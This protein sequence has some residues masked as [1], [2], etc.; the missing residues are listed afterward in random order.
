MGVF[1]DVVVGIR[2][3]WA[4]IKTKNRSS[5][6]AFRFKCEFPHQRVPFEINLDREDRWEG[7]DQ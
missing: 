5:S 1:V 6:S 2:C 7:H 4:E 3:H